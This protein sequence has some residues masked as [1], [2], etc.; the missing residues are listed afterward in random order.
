MKKII[1]LNI[2]SVLVLIGCRNNQ[3]EKEKAEMAQNNMYTMNP[4]YVGTYTKKESHVN[5]QAEGIY[6]VYQ[7][8]ETGNLE[9]GNTVARVTNPSFVK[10]S[11]DNQHLYAVSELGPNDGP[12][13]FLFSYK[14]NPDHSLEELGSVSTEGFAPCYIAE[15]QSGQFIFVANYVGGVVVMYEKNAN[16]SLKK[17]QKVT[18]ENPDRSHPHSVNISADNK[19][20]YIPDLGNDRIWIFNL[21]TEGKALEPHDTPFIQLPEGSGPRHFAFSKNNDYAYSINELNGSISAFKIGNKGELIHLRDIS[22][23]PED[24]KGKNSAADLHLH[25]SGKYLYAS[26]RGHNSIA[27]F[28]I[29]AENGEL[30]NIGYTSTQ[31]L[32]PRNFAISPNGEFLYVANQD[33]N[34]ITGFKVNTGKGTLEEAVVD[35]KAKTPVC[36]EFLD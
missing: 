34:T 35:L 2:L 11:K 7:D 3:D 26:N 27:A 16:G 28:S 30:K 15:D 9:M 1:L 5:G 31:G 8:P 13:G 6:T 33:S 17:L 23:L 10:T 21:N 19:F 4:I 20:V 25:P 22:S 24:F 18:L 36:I 29:N 14:I 12:S 32:T